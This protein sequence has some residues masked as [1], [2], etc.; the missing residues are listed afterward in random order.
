M[1]ASGTRFEKPT[2]QSSN[3]AIV[4]TLEEVRHDEVQAAVGHDEL[5]LGRLPTIEP[6]AKLDES[7]DC[8]GSLLLSVE[9][10]LGQAKAD[11]GVGD[12][13]ERHDVPGDPQGHY[14]EVAPDA[15]PISITSAR[16]R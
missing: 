14:A 13:R 2:C 3:A 7:V 11:G 4:G 1:R 12:V 9:Q 6:L 15:A 5:R 16:P 10:A 8:R